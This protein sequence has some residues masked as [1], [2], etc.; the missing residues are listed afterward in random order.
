MN[1]EE[2]KKRGI[3]NL[4]QRLMLDKSY[5]VN[6]NDVILKKV[7]EL[8]KNFEYL[9]IRDEFLDNLENWQM[10]ELG[11]YFGIEPTI[12]KIALAIENWSIK[13]KGDS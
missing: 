10:D 11:K 3:L 12:T 4:I 13:E 8:L 6:N 9:Q 7:L 5:Y 2:I 1:R